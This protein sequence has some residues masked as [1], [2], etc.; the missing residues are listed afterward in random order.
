MGVCRRGIALVCLM[1]S[2]GCRPSQAPLQVPGAA[3][4][5]RAL[6]V[7][8]DHACALDAQGHAWC[9]GA[10]PAGQLGTDW[11]TES[12]GITILTPKTN[13]NGEAV[14]EPMASMDVQTFFYECSRS[15]LAV[16]GGGVFVAVAA[17]RS[18]ERDFLGH[19]CALTA[20]GAAYCWGFNNRGQ[21]G[22][23]TAC[24]W[25]EQGSL[26]DACAVATPRPVQ[27]GQRFQALAL[28]ARHS[29][30]LALDGVPWC[31]GANG[32]GELGQGAPGD[33]AATPVAL[34]GSP[35][36]DALAA[37]QGFTC[38]LAGGRASC[39]GRGRGAPEAVDTGEVSLLALRASRDHACALTASGG[40]LCWPVREG[41]LVAVSVGEGA[42][43]F[44]SLGVAGVGTAACGVGAD[45]LATCFGP[46]MQSIVYDQAGGHLLPTVFDGPLPGAHRFAQLDG[47]EG[48]CGLTVEG[49]VL[50]WQRNVGSVIDPDALPPP[51]ERAR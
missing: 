51:P 18:G 14:Q 3:V 4:P 31:W 43:P 50:C 11:L 20:G 19:T 39:W 10:A 38:G 13:L 35:R 21:V 48:V 24:G 40:L 8:G 34:V 6:S 47:D 29:C 22:L 36:Y 7:G 32:Q 5:F 37:G 9:W 44:L 28:G 30:A 2:A 33:D 17:S 46:L 25:D 16:A 41:P 45:G 42:G 26:T 15:P 23:G 1:L 27:T 49:A 12:C